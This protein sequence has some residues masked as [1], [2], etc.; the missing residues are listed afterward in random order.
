MDW[1][2]QSH[3]RNGLWVREQ[4]KRNRPDFNPSRPR[5]DGRRPGLGGPAVVSVM[6]MRHV[7]PTRLGVEG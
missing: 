3:E 5:S 6:S 4:M 7:S 2:G 1:A